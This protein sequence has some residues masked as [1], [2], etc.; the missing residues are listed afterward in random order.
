MQKTRWRKLFQQ[1]RCPLRCH[2]EWA[3]QL[4]LYLAGCYAP[5]RWRAVHD[6]EE[7]VHEK[8]MQQAWESNTLP[9]GD[10]H[11]P[12]WA[13]SRS[14]HICATLHSATHPVEGALSLCITVSC[15][16]VCLP[17]ETKTSWENMLCLID[18]L[19]FFEKTKVSLEHNEY[20]KSLGTKYVICAWGFLSVCVCVCAAQR[21]GDMRAEKSWW[22]DQKIK[23]ERYSK[24]NISQT[25]LNWCLGRGNQD[26]C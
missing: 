1:I 9:K 17:C 18:G 24:C 10:S 15:L 11:P 4:S 25:S 6:T 19:S 22:R 2:D 26:A 16:P 7:T 14:L 5:H 3:K 8:L 20:L 12:H 21:V 23:S 13:H